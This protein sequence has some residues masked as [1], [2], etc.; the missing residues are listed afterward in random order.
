MEAMI[1]IPFTEEQLRQLR[2]ERFHHPHP[3]VQQ[4]AEAL[5]LK[6]EG[7]PH[8]QICRIVGI[9]QNTL[10]AYFREFLSGGVEALRHLGFRGPQSELA[11]HR[12][13]LEVYF[14]EHPPATIK[15]AVA[16]IEELTG[17]QRSE[18]QAREFLK[19]MGL[20]R[21]KVGFVP[22]KADV[23]EQ[24]RFKNEELEPRLAEAQADRRVL[25]F[26]DASHFVLA[27]FL[28][29]LWCLVRRV[30]R[31]PAGRQRFN[32]LAALNA[33]THELVTVTNDTYI[34][35][36]SVCELL[37][38]V[39]ALGL[40]APVTLVLDNARYQKCLLVQQLADELGIELL[41]LPSYSPNLNL[42]ERLWK[43]VKKKVLNSQYYADFGTFKA[44]ISGCIADAPTKY[45]E[46]L[47]SLLTLRF[48]TFAK[49]QFLAA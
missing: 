17:V 19:S 13:T 31:A 28:G 14:A 27:P 45:K 43:F 34:N 4:K 8:Q 36:Q 10:R 29:Y 37:R 39:A 32:V 22:A 16:K 40:K 38:K 41:F 42:I 49:A 30:V 1:R 12:E 35:A 5:L 48:Q 15:E 6:N 7:L 46:E 33:I 18:S 2:H 44:A 24:E 21:L 20:R 9:T 25:F 26:V 47:D 23:D 11:A 3:R